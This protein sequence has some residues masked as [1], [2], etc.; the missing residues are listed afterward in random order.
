MEKDL[1]KQLYFKSSVDIF[2]PETS[3]PLTAQGSFIISISLITIPLTFVLKMESD[4]P[5]LKTIIDKLI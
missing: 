4:T 1:L 2:M 5:V 3:L